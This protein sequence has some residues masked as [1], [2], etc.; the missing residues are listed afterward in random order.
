[1]RDI[2]NA[3]KDGKKLTSSYPLPFV[4]KPSTFRDA[5][6]NK[7]RP[8]RSGN[9]KKRGNKGVRQNGK[10][11]MERSLVFRE[12]T[13]R[14]LFEVSIAKQ[15]YN[16]KI[17]CAYEPFGIRYKSRIT[18]AVCSECGNKGAYTNDIYIPDWV[19]WDKRG[20]I[21]FFIEAKGK[22]SRDVRKKHKA[23]L[24]TNPLIDIRLVFQKNNW[25]TTNHVQRYTDWARSNGYRAAVE[26]PPKEW[27][28]ES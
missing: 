18:R 24:D 28:S 19:V 9:G 3:R 11:N 7:V 21:K 8:T 10:A 22:L 2:Y 27:F 26:L 23:I 20:G 15:L 12:R 1:M 14:S 25:V 6:P 17:D 16:W 13:Y 4:D 5:T